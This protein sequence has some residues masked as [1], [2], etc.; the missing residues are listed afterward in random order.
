MEDWSNDT[1]SNISQDNV[2]ET[3]DFTYSTKENWI[4][5]LDND[6]NVWQCLHCRKKQYAKN[7]SNR[8]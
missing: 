1:T 8:I 7:T 6:Q 4:E 3:I 2:I 5:V